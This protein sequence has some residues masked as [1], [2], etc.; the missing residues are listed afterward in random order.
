MKKFSKII[1]VFVLSAFIA[2][3]VFGILGIKGHHHEPGCPFMPGEKVICEMNIFEHISAWQQSFTGIV[4]ALMVILLAAIT[5]WFLWKQEWPPD[6]PILLR[7][8]IISRNSD[9]PNLYKE[10]FSRGILNP[11]IP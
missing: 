8:R 4:P 11:K 5:L 3:G 6:I 2:V 7:V 10:L 1:T 9:I